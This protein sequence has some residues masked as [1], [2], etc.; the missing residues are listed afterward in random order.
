MSERLTVT[1]LSKWK[2]LSTAY[3]HQKESILYVVVLVVCNL[4]KTSFRFV[5]FF[6]Q[7]KLQTT[8]R[9]NK[10]VEQD[11]KAYSVHLQLLKFTMN[12]NKNTK[13]QEKSIAASKV[14][15]KINTLDTVLVRLLKKYQV[16]IQ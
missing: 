8:Y 4:Y 6:V 2:V 14:M 15:R 12:T 9:L 13:K 10:S 16:R 3:R 1:C 11:T 7:N 5:Y